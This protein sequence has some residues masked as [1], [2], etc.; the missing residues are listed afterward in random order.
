MQLY[1]LLFVS[2]VISIVIKNSN[3]C[4]QCGGAHNDGIVDD[5]LLDTFIKE[6]TSIFYH[7][8]IIP[9]Q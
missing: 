2:F 7:P 5:N 1:P 3:S 8:Q 6:I 4:C 9:T